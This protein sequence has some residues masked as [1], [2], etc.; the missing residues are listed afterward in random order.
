MSEVGGLGFMS[1][2]TLIFITLK[3]LNKIDWSW[4]WIL[5]PIWI[6]FFIII[7]II[8]LTFI[9]GIILEVFT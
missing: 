9:I 3:L 6:S 1:V 8:L 5:S 7:A 2:L 4:W